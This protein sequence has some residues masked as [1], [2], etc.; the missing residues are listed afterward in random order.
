MSVKSA[1]NI[2]IAGWFMK[3]HKTCLQDGSVQVIP[4]PNR[5]LCFCI[6][7][8]FSFGK[9]EEATLLIICWCYGACGMHVFESPSM[10]SNLSSQICLRENLRRSLRSFLTMAQRRQRIYDYF[11]P[12]GLTARNKKRKKGWSMLCRFGCCCVWH[13]FHIL[14]LLNVSCFRHFTLFRSFLVKPSEAWVP[15]HIGQ[16]RAKESRTSAFV[17]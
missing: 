16:G 11:L 5:N 1:P 15:I 17:V 2:K 10:I 4:N 14:E 7:S 9:K 6:N 12:L 13:Q 8:D 3:W